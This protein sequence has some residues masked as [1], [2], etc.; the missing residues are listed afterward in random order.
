MKTRESGMPEED[1]WDG[2][3]DPSRVLELVGVTEACQ[4]VADF[5]CG[6]G[7]FTILPHLEVR[8]WI[9][10]RVQNHAEPGRNRLAFT[11]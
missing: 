3:F 9:S 5:G 1:T 4:D 11:A 7:T 2:F 8:P 10:V 6:Y